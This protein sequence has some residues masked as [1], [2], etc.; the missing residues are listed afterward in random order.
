MSELRHDPTTRAWVILAPERARRPHQKPGQ[1]H[2]SELPPWDEFCPFCPGNEVQTPR[3]VFRLPVT[4]QGSEWEVRVVPNRFAALTPEAEIS[5]KEDGRFFRRMQGFGIHEVIVEIPSHN[6]PT[7]LM[8]CEQVEKVL[9]AYQ[10]RYN[11]LKKDSYIK[12]ITIF[13]N[14]GWASGTSLSHPHS[15][16][17]ATPVV[18]PYYHRKFNVAHEYYIDAGRCLYCDLLAAEL[19]KGERIVAETGQFIVIHPYASRVPYETWI[20]PKSHC[21]S[22]GLFP[23]KYLAGLA[24]V[25]KNTLLGL[26]QELDNPAF[27]LMVDSTITEDED[28][29]YY[30]WH[31]RIIPRQTTVAGFEMGSGIYISTALPEQ[32]A[33]RMRECTAALFRSES[34]P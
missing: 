17:V 30:H 20:I 23:G 15:Q 21:A 10:E 2:D 31:I 16:L 24:G 32:T 29:P 1:R 4:G 26:Y 18:A 3:E 13:K 19:E 7:A 27:N 25:L 5:R 14:H 34:S 8:T 22:F 11:A 12:C 9:I 33:K 28:D 6:M